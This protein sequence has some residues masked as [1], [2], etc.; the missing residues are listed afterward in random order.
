MTG[1]A[2]GALAPAPAIAVLMATCNGAA[3]LGDQLDSL[4]AQSLPPRWLVVSDDG[5][6]D[7]TRAVL[8]AFAARNPR[9]SLHLLD[10]PRQGPA[11]NFLF[12]LRHVP[13]EAGLVAIA[14]QD[15][16]WLQDKLMRGARMLAAQPC[17]RPALL[18]T[19]TLVCDAGLQHRRPSPLWRRPFG[20]RHALVQS[21]A[22]G[23]TMMMNR[24]TVSLAAAAAEAQQVVMHDWWLYQIVSGA[25]GQVLFD[26]QP[27]VLY[28]QHGANQIGAS[29][30][31]A[32]R[33][34]RLRALVRGDFRRWNGIN[35]R[36][37]QASAHRLTPENRTLVTGFA[38]LQH[39]G[40]GAR[41]TGLHRLGLYRQGAAGRAS[42]W[43]AALLGRI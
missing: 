34:R 11:A 9:I 40:L 30:G 38:H 3:Y 23:N 36:A 31:I 24:A 2:P 10:G 17:G 27:Q 18:G 6:T 42:L 13:A 5:S 22:G 25:G 26:P 15:D 7:G 16:V 39:G 21:V 28:R 12:L 20:F 8:S 43:L 35:L 32:A 1:A 4:A 14:D 29:D 33:L 19:R 37:L 41:L